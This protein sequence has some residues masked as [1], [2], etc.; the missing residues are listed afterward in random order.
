MVDMA[1]GGLGM[2]QGGVSI[3]YGR[4]DIARGPRRG[5]HGPGWSEYRLGKGGYCPES[6]E[7]SA[8]S[9]VE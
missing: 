8:W 2:V 9:G 6:R 5:R 4:V 1:Q 3:G 7:G